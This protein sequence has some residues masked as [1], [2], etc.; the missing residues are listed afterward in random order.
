MLRKKNVYAACSR[1]I[2]GAFEEGCYT[3]KIALSV[4]LDYRKQEITGRQ[5]MTKR[6]ILCRL[7][8]FMLRTSLTFQILAS[9]LLRG[10]D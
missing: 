7:A 3:A 4:L 5:R 1:G 6:R 2:A 8:T 9:V 10:D